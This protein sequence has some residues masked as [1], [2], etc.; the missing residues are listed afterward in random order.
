MLFPLI[1]AGM[2]FANMED[3][4]RLRKLEEQGVFPAGYAAQA[5]EATIHY[6]ERIAWLSEIRKLPGAQPYAGPRPYR[7]G[8]S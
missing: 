8:L 5:T 7:N 1:E 4:F 2:V 6:L 3:L